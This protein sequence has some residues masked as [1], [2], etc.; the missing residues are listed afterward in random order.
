M[1]LV[2][3]LSLQIRA[4]G[5]HAGCC[6]ESV[7]TAGSVPQGAPCLLGRLITKQIN[8]KN[9]NPCKP[10]NIKMELAT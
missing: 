2:L 10:I 1:V 6:G 3:L 5:L 9:R 8:I 7:N 4:E